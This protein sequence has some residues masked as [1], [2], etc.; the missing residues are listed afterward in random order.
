VARRTDPRIPRAGEAGVVASL[1]FGAIEVFFIR[2]RRAGARAVNSC[3]V[4]AKKEVKLGAPNAVGGDVEAGCAGVVAG[5]AT[6]LAVLKVIWQARAGAVDGS[7]VRA[8][9]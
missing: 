1:A 6:R 4:G 2:L 3:E 9:L 8:L 7:E 5:S